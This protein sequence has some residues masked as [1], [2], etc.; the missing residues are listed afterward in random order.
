MLDFT[1]LKK[2][3]TFAIHGA[4][5]STQLPVHPSEDNTQVG[6]LVNEAGR[7][8]FLH[9]WKFRMAAPVDLGFTSG[10]DSIELPANFG[11]IKEIIYESSLTNFFELRTI[12][13]IMK[14]RRLSSPPPFRYIGAIVYPEPE[15]YE[16]PLYPR[17]EIYPIPDSDL[18][19]ALSFVYWRDWTELVESTDRPAIPLWFESTLIRYVQIFCAGYHKEN[20]MPLEDRID[21]F[22]NSRMFSNA[23]KR[24]GRVQSRVGPLTNG[25]S[26]H[27]RGSRVTDLDFGSIANPS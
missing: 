18:P 13:D 17:L 3:A 23:R 24:D 2:E 20:I 6:Q 16:S 22:E 9:Q 15:S 8:A 12:G 1:A 14:L 11:E 10:V 25:Y 4:N 19:K 26:S 5:P 27:P 21:K 7:A